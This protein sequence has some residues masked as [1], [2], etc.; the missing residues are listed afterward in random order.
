MKGSHGHEAKTDGRIA[1]GG[2]HERS[3]QRAGADTRH[4]ENPPLSSPLAPSALYD[5]CTRNVG[6]RCPPL[7]G[8]LVYDFTI[9]GVEPYELL[10]GGLIG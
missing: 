9:T 10:A 4:A 8:G 7:L 2:V 5:A 1:R 3:C 6:I